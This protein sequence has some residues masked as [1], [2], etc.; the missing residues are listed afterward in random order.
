MR[1]PVRQETGGHDGTRGAA[2]VQRW[3]GTLVGRVSYA[4]EGVY[5]A[6]GVR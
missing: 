6:K 3:G 2:Q 4:M 5:L 1:G